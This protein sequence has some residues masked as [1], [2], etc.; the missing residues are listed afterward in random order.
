MSAENKRAIGAHYEELS[1]RYL[2]EKGYTI[3]QRNFRCRM[4]EID[5]IVRD[6]DYLVFAEVKYRS[7]DD[8]GGG[9][10]AVHSRKRSTIRKVA[11]YYLQQTRTEAYCRFDVIVITAAGE[12]RHY[13]N[14]FI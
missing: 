10:A 1:A 12:I 13:I 6:G 7:T 5:L 2:M 3:V 9:E 8:F 4:G 14:A 11:A